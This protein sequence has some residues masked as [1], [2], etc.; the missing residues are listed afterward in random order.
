MDSDKIVLSRNTITNISKYGIYGIPFIILIFILFYILKTKNINNL[1]SPTNIKNVVNNNTESEQK[2]NTKI[3]NLPIQEHKNMETKQ[4]YSKYEEINYPSSLTEPNGYISR[5]QICFRNK[6]GDF[7]FMRKRSGCMACQVDTTQNN[8]NY[9]N[10]NVIT[11]CL[12]SDIKNE[13]D[14]SVYIKQ[15]CLDR[16]AMMQDK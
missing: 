7:D 13:N 3:I 2:S 11:T 6:M 4:I 16:C 1:Y 9:L 14:K 12:Y 10:T 5:D 8:K 15:E